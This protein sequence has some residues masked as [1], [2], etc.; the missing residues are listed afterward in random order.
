MILVTGLL[1]GSY[2]AFYLSGFNPI[3]VL[4][5]TFLP[6]KQALL[7][8][9]VLVTFQFIASIILISATVVIYK[10]LQYVKDRDLGYDQD[11]LVMVNSTPETDKSFD[12]LKNDLLQTGLVAS[13]NRTSSPITDI[14]MSTSGIRWAGAPPSSNLV[15]GFLFTNEDFAQ[16]VHTKVLEG[17]DFRSGDSDAVVFNKEAIRLMGLKVPV[18]TK[19]NWAGKDRTIVGVLDNMVITSPYKPADPLM[20]VYENRWSGKMNL[21]LAKNADLKNALTAVE[22]TYKKYSIEYPFEYKFIDEEF[23]QKFINEQLIGKLSVIF[24][25]LA[26]FICCLGLFG[27]VASSIERRR[28]E[29]G[30]R[31]VLGASLQQLL[32][33]MSKE[34]L[35][36]VALAFVVAIPIAWWGMNKWLQNYSYRTNVSVGVFAMVGIVILF[37]ALLTVSLNASRAALSNPVKTLRSE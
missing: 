16:T 5:G 22:K 13:V 17:R 25:G 1:A 15:I 6:G 11:N 7:P 31:K 9:K 2:P 26:I 10:Q 33:L 24:A 14:Y 36:L 4:K 23:N 37:I 29:I 30:I 8:R 12:A 18:G 19:I 28:K 34:F 21:R 3:K 20:L 35:W 27:L 32:F